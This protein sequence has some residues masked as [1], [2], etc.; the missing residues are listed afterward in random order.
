MESHGCENH[1]QDKGKYV[2]GN[3]QLKG[4]QTRIGQ[5]DRERDRK[6]R[7]AGAETKEPPTIWTTRP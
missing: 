4:N 5:R 7:D 1:T 3:F 6:S 2:E